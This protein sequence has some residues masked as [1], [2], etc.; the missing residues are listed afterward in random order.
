MTDGLPDALAHTL[1]TGV[2]LWTVQ[3]VNEGAFKSWSRL[4]LAYI[5][6]LLLASLVSLMVTLGTWAY[7]LGVI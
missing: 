4:E 7:T 5:G 6:L 2:L 3:L 1:V